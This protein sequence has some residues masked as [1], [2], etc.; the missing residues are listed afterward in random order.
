[1]RLYV[2]LEVLRPLESFAAKLASMRFQGNMDTDVRG[3]VV[4]FHDGDTAATPR[5]GEVEVVSTLASDMA[6][7]DMVL[8]NDHGD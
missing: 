2:F 7:A 4:A 8:S 5:T 1:V 6:L 3:D